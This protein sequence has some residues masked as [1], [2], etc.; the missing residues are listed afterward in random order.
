MQRNL[1]SIVAA[2]LSTPLASNAQGDATIPTFFI[3][4]IDFQTELLKEPCTC[5]EFLGAYK[6]FADQTVSGDSAAFSATMDEE[7]A[8]CFAAC[9]PSETTTNTDFNACVISNCATK[10]ASTEAATV[11]TTGAAEFFGTTG[12]TE[13]TTVAG[14]TGSTEAA[15]EGTT[16]SATTT[17]GAT[18]AAA[19]T[20]AT[21]AKETTTT[22]TKPTYPQPASA[23]S[24]ASIVSVSFPF[25]AAYALFKYAM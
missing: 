8:A 3:E 6:A 21:E 24:S 13:A 5:T 15:V 4:C 22:A 11:G 17:T 1:L 9:C 20:G 2:V 10:T 18:E 25:V 19:T 16:E 14:T 12:S 7:T 23:P